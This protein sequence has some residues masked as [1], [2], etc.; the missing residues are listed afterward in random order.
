VSTNNTKVT[1]SN[2]LRIESKVL[3]GKLWRTDSSIVK[4]IVPGRVYH[5]NILQLEMKS[6]KGLII[7]SVRIGDKLNRQKLKKKI[8]VILYNLEL[9]HE[10]KHKIRRRN[11]HKFLK[12]LLNPYFNAMFK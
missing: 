9:S 7:T 1:T 3:T 10:D 5:V 11:K 6:V 12:G 4:L 8:E 2:N